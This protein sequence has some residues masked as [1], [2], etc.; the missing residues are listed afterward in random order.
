MKKEMKNTHYMR[1]KLQPKWIGPYT[2]VEVKEIGWYIV[3]DKYLKVMK[4]GIPINQSKL[5]FEPEMRQGNNIEKNGR[6]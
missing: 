6:Q 4:K 5:Y 1:G 2:I 3:T